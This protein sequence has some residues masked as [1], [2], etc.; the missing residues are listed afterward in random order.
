MFQMMQMGISLF[1]KNPTCYS[2]P[3]SNVTSC[4]KPAPPFTYVSDITSHNGAVSEPSW[5]APCPLP[6][7]LGLALGWTDRG[8]DQSSLARFWSLSSYGGFPVSP[9]FFIL[10]L[11]HNLRAGEG[12][13]TC[14]C[15]LLETPES[16]MTAQLCNSWLSGSQTD[17][18]APPRFFHQK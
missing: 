12:Y 10:G 6:A 11:G 17:H 15:S 9:V 13:F 4:V 5:P 16:S 2:R 7:P 3:C 1:R 14:C 18:M 8:S